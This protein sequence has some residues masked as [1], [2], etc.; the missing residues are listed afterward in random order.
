MHRS[1][2]CRLAVTITNPVV[3]PEIR[4][5]S[6]RDGS[7]AAIHC[8]VRCPFD[9]YSLSWRVKVMKALQPTHNG[10][11]GM[12]AGDGTSGLV[13]PILFRTDECFVMRDD[14]LACNMTAE[15]D[16]VMRGDIFVRGGD[17]RRDQG[18]N[19]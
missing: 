10:R 3:D 14:P 15:D 2:R 8:G 6:F 16:S 19:R 9:I 7:N 4:F 12:N 1:R 11:D 13:G 5:V 18:C 17:T